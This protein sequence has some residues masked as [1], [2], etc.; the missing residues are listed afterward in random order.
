LEN[1]EEAFSNHVAES[2]R[3]H[4][5][6]FAERLREREATL[7]EKLW[8]RKARLQYLTDRLQDRKVALGRARFILQV[9]TYDRILQGV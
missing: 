1:L 4:E 8:G 9:E 3:E 2:R 5:D 7:A 6:A